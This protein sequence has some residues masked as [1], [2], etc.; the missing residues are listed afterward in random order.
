MVGFLIAGVPVSL[1]YLARFALDNELAFFGTLALMLVIGAYVW[2]LSV[3]T[4]ARVLN[5]RRETTLAALS[6]MSTPIS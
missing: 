2:W 6:R 4:A 5:D 3:E 1:A